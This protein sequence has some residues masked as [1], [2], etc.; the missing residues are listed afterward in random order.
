M[1]FGLLSLLGWGW[2]CVDD[3]WVLVLCVG[4]EVKA[5]VYFCGGAFVGVLL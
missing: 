2:M 4:V 3:V 1:L 5:V